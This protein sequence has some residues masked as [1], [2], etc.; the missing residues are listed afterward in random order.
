ML[1]LS[2]AL[3]AAAPAV[4]TA[5]PPQWQADVAAVALVESWD[6]NESH[7]WLSG[8]AAGVDRQVYRGLS[9]RAEG[10][11]LRVAQAGNDALLGGI[12]VGPRL[13]WRSPPSRPFVDLA[14]G[15]SYA[16][17]PAPARGTRFN[18]LLMATAGVETPVA[19]L[20]ATIGARWFHV[21]NNGLAG[22]A[23]NPD[24]QALGVVLGIGW[25]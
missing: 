9:L 23:R 2:A 1:L 16:T 13:R 8:V 17:R 5:Q 10:V 22:R 15:V 7:E 18:Y 20:R 21:S 3:A 12:T 4:A 14:A 6:R 25:R 11:A 24:I 19:G